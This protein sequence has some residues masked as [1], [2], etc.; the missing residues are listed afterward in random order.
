MTIDVLILG[1]GIGGIVTANL[2]MRK[3]RKK[4]LELRI[5]LVGNSPMHTYQ[6]GLLF[7]PF[8]KPGYRRLEDIQKPNAG[9]IASGIDYI[10][11]HITAID[12]VQ[13]RVTTE[14]Q[15]LSYDWLVLALGCRTVIDEVDGLPEQWG[16]SVHGFYTP[17]SALRLAQALDSFN[18]GDLVVN[19][20]EMPVSYTHLTLPTTIKPCR[21]RWSPY[22]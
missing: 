8:Q 10:G 5:R 14:H 3:A 6:P 2:L 17:D 21:S 1:D 16:K 11:E 4:D 22:H 12:T 7:L 18:G 9:L 19:V 20:A 15:T 13:R